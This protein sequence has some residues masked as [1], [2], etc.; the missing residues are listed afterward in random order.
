MYIRFSLEVSSPGCFGSSH[1]ELLRGLHPFCSDR[2]SSFSRLFGI[3]NNIE[4]F[5]AFLFSCNWSDS[6]MFTPFKYNPREFPS[7]GLHKP[8]YTSVLTE[9]LDQ[10]RSRY[11]P[12][13]IRSCLLD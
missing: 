5:R 1:L 13:V 10:F 4:L 12:N 9:R 3:R 7:M 11:G 8:E 2:G 6:W